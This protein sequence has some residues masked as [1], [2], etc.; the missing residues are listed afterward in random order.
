MEYIVH[1]TKIWLCC[2]KLT[3]IW[4]GKTC[5]GQVE[6]WVDGYQKEQKGIQ[7]SWILLVMPCVTCVFVVHFR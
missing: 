6:I 1:G 4:M 5:F 2:K 3:W 7:A